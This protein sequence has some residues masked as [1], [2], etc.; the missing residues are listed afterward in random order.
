MA[1]DTKERVFEQEIEYWLTSGV[2]KAERYVKGNPSGFNREYAMDTNALAAFV[3]DT[4]PD[5]WK[6]LIKR[7][8]SESVAMAEFLKRLNA[9]L[10]QRGMI[11]VL[12]HGIAD[13]GV[14]VRLAYFK[15]G[16]GMNKSASALYDKNV[17]Q[18]TRQVKYSITNENSIDTVIFLNGLPIITIELK[19]PLTGQT[20]KNAIDQYKN[21]R[22]PREA[23]LAFKK[24]AIVHFA[25][26]TDEVWMTTWLRKQDTVF[27]PFNKG[28]EKG[29]GNP[30]VANDYRTSYLWKEILRRD[31]LLD[32]LHRFVRMTKDDKSGKEKL[33]FPRYHQLDAVRKIVGDVYSNGAGKNYLIQHSAGSGKSNSMA[34]LAHHLTNLHDANDDVVFH[35][36]IVVTDRRVLD[37]QLQRDI[38][39]ME[40]KDGVVVR[41]DK[42]SKQLAT[43][44]EKGEKIIICTLRK[45]PFVD[46]QKVAAAG[47]RFAVIVD[48]AHSSQT[49]KASERLKEVLA[50]ISAQGEDAIEKKLHEY[51]VEEAKAEDEGKDP[52]EEIAAEMAAHGPRKNL[53]FFAFTA[54]PKQKTIEIFGTKTAEGKPEPFHLYS[55]RQAIE[56]GFIFNV[57]ENYTTY[58]TYFQIGKKITD[59][60]LYAKGQANK[61]LGKYMS[62]HSY[63]LAQKTEIIVEHFRGQVQHRIGGK[64]KAMLV[65]GSRLHAV[66]Y[67]FEFLKYIEKMGYTDLGVLVAFSGAVKD[68]VTGGIKEYTEANLNDFPDTET[69]DKFAAGEYQLLLVAEKY[70]TGF[71]QPLL[72]TMYVDKKLSGVKA[73][74]TLSRVNRTCPGKTETFVLD[75]VNSRG[76][77]LNAFQDYYQETGIAESTDPNTVYDIKNALD[78]FMIYTDSEIN[79]FAKV[80]FKETKSQGNIDLARLNSFVDPAVDRYNAS[81]EGQNKMDFRGA[82]TKFIRLYSF[83]THIINL[84]DENLHK[85]YAYAKCLLRKLPKDTGDRTPNLD[86]DVFLQYYRLQKTYEGTILMAKEDG[87]LHGKTTGTGLP[88]EDEKEKLSRIIQELNERLGMNF[89]EM[90]KVLE[91][92]VQDMAGNA[93]MVL[94][95]KNPLDLF[96]IVYDNA[97]IDVVLSRMAKNHEFCEKYLED[98]AFRSEID[99]ILLPLVHDR[100]SRLTDTPQLTIVDVIAGDGFVSAL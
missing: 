43:A 16:S 33:I 73:V 52:D 81:T 47:K 50:D 45:F 74:Q 41:V 3:K 96:K 22:S 56:E 24:R 19:N 8:G 55:M 21:D 66:R 17:L 7:H 53:S 94:R 36:V 4:Q 11:D 23:L 31:S 91:Q 65:T 84:G 1:I 40:H 70:Q 32:I 87:V 44:L 76:D 78:S 88:L 27:I 46:V 42:N 28:C 51:A 34:W 93:E 10:N 99:K 12:R 6:A 72:H 71:D 64:A 100:L 39:N 86:N 69:P 9:E 48:E 57:L 38:F 26:D 82:L 61:A 30:P 15:P 68:N 59:D 54:T 79:A 95:S 58:E 18:I 35:S 98:E 92:F 89:T 37:K 63:N 25:A 80:F 14:Y 97:I 83:L 62:L 2:K 90:D 13:L 60:P 29:A 67:Y 20:Y 5:E 49:G 77:I 85:F 75:F